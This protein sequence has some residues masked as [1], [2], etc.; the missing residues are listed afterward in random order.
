MKNDFELRAENSRHTHRYG[1]LWRAMDVGPPMEIV[2]VAQVGLYY[3]DCGEGLL[4]MCSSE[5]GLV[6]VGDGALTLAHL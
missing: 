5:G 2:P 1:P 6:G 4:L 3:C